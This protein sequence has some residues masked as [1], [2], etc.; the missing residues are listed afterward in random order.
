MGHVLMENRHGLVV[1]AA[2]THATGTAEREAAL[3]LLDRRGGAAPITVGGDKNYDTQDFVARCRAIKVVP[4]VAQ[5]TSG[6][7]SAIDR[8]ATRHP[9]YGISQVIRKRIEEMFGWSKTIGG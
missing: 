2:T 1:D 6:R 5:N 9:G 8:R 3:D 4:H 7:R